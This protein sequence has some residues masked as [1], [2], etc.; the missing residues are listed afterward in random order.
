MDRPETLKGDASALD[1]RA[2]LLPSY[3]SWEGLA[4]RVEV[5]D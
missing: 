2:W 3:R 4:G 5:E 1:R